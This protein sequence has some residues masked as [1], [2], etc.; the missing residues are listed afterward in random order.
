MANLS[1]LLDKEASLEI[2]AVL[3]EARSRASEIVAKAREE[4]DTVVAQQE[5]VAKTQYDAALVRSRSGAQLEASSLRLRAQHDAVERVFK[6]AR[7]SLEKLISDKAA[8][9]DVLSRLLTEAVAGLGGPSEVAAVVVNPEDRAVA[10][11]VVAAQDLGAKLETN[12]DVQ[13]G[14]RV[15]ASGGNVTLENTLF[16]RLEA[17]QDELASDVSQA[18]FGRGANMNAKPA[19]HLSADSAAEA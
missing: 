4:A 2:E 12:A 8:Y 7:D 11:K 9:A 17:V 15:R 19:A 5:R 10:E 1:A 3:S 16:G 6:A 14:V 13:G 18:L